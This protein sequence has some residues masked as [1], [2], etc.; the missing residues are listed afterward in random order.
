MDIWHEPY[1]SAQQAVDLGYDVVNAQ[2]VYMYIV[3][4]LYGD[5]LN[6][7]FLYNEWEPVKWE[8][9]T[10]PY[11]HPR[12]KGGMFCLW[13]DVSDANGLSM[14]DSHERLLPGIQAVSEKM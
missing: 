3:P 7:Q 9:T 6:S 8:T 12:V 10:L 5:Y 1:G 14:D 11:G 13:N 2:N 4:T